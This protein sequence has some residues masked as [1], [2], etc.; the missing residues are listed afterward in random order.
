MKKKIIIDEISPDL[1]SY[2]KSGKLNPNPIIK[3]ID[4]NLNINNLDKLLRIHFILTKDVIKF[5]E[6]LEIRIRNI[7]TTTI[8]N[9]FISKSGVVGRIDWKNTFSERCKINPKNKTIYVCSRK[10]KEFEIYENLVLKELLKKIYNVIY[11]DLNKIITQNKPYNWLNQWFD[12]KK[13]KDILFNV[14]HKNIYLRKINLKDNYLVSDRMIL[15]TMKSRKPLYRDAANLLIRYKKIMNRDIYEK[16]A[17]ELLRETFVNPDNE[18]LLFELY[19]IIKIIRNYK[20]Y[21]FNIIEDDKISEWTDG[22]YKYKLFHNS[23]GSFE[24]KESLKN[25]ITDSE[26]GFIQR[27]IKVITKLQELVDIKKGDSLWG[28]R[29]DIIL[30]K[31]KGNNIDSLFIGEVKNTSNKYYAI[32]GLKELLEYIALIKYKDKY[33]SS[34]LNKLFI[35]SKILGGLFIDN[36]SDFKLKSTNSNIKVYMFGNQNIKL[37]I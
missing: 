9:I 30:E 21:K 7:K 18:N 14:Y 19:W 1:F 32:Q 12:K 10:D 35:D 24:F 36:I 29:P 26:D 6:K 8:N 20:N 16:E 3:D 22:N 37:N 34:D 25:L 27:E 31:W 2:I 28:G 11:K 17:K 4:V 5:I 13:L 15:K 23:T 33:V